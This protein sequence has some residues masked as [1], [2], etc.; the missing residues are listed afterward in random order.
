M[1]VGG[2]VQRKRRADH[3]AQVTG[4]KVGRCL[5]ENPPLTLS[6]LGPSKHRGR[7]HPGEGYEDTGGLIKALTCVARSGPGA[8]KNAAALSVLRD[9]SLVP[10]AWSSQAAQCGSA[11]SSG[12]DSCGKDSS[13]R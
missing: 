12:G 4:V 10:A 1:C 2:F 7:R 5:L 11:G 8:S 3:D 13:A 6:V 9:R